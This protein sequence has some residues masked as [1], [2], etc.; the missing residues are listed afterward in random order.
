MKCK[1]CGSET[2]I[3]HQQCRMDV[4]VN[5]EGD[6]ESDMPGGCES[7]IY[8]AEKPYG[9]FTCNRCGAEY[10]ELDGRDPSHIN[11][12]WKQCRGNF[13]KMMDHIRPS[14]KGNNEE[15]VQL[16]R[17]LLYDIAIIFQLP[18]NHPFVQI[19]R[20]SNDNKFLPEL[21]DR[22]DDDFF[23]L[24]VQIPTT[25][26]GALGSQEAR[27]FLSQMEAAVNTAE[28]IEELFIRPLRE[29]SFYMGVT[30]PK[31]DVICDATF[32]SV[33]DG[34]YRIETSCKVNTLTKEVFHIEISE[35]SADM[36]QVLEGE[37]IRFSDG[38]EHPVSG[39]KGNGGYWYE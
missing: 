6:F 12:E 8:D 33:W 17:G 1:I 34:G 36:F 23:P 21:Y 30:I 39:A 32:I 3:A 35:N 2:F 7:A 38:T 27:E 37:Y 13:V 10:E 26:Y 22:V 20:K 14:F 5:G 11:S 31:K 16:W 25:S 18:S 29:G 24:G 28:E 15:R 4:F 9:P 19:R